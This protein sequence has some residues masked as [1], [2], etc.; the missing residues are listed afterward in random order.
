MKRLLAGGLNRIYSLG[1]VFR[2]R[3][4]GPQHNPEFTMLEWYRAGEDWRAI[5]ADVEDLVKACTRE[6]SVSRV[7]ECVLD[8]EWERLS[9]GEACEKFGG[10][11]LHGDED[12]AT[13]REKIPAHGHGVPSDS[14]DSDWS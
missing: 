5:A 4:A 3:E 10:V 12:A 11:R 6:F 13:L 1:K 7:G 2:R 8:G 14:Y 9:V